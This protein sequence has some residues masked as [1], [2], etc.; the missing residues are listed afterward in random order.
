MQAFEKILC[1][2]DFSENSVKALQWTES[3]ARKFGSEVIV[4]HVM[5]PYPVAADLGFDYEKYQSVVT[6][7]LNNFVMPLK[8]KHET[9]LSTGEAANKIV[10]LAKSLNASLVVMGTSGLEGAA[11]K[12]LGSTTERVVRTG[13]VPVLTIAPACHGPG[14][15]ETHKV[16][17]P[18]SS[19]KKPPKGYGRLRSIVQ[20]L[21][22][23]VTLTHIVEFNNPMFDSNF[24]ANPFLVTSYETSMLKDELQRIGMKI[25]DMEN[26]PE[27]MI[28]FGQPAQEIMKETEDEQYDFVL[29]GARKRTFL[30]RFVESTAYRI[31]SHSKAPVITVKVD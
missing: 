9:L 5:D 7:D 10:A 8:I 29:M 6:K 2:V 26:P 22:A 17:M 12:L 23:E 13:D 30:T 1:P 27:A 21:Q 18:L 19:V 20:A 31:L 14:A 3:L 16:L 15:R 11:H 4:L 24:D 28:G 25:L